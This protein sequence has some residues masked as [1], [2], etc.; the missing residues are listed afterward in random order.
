MMIRGF[1]CWQQTR[2]PGRKG[3]MHYAHT[4]FNLYEGVVGH[5][6]F[7][8][9]VQQLTSMPVLKREGTQHPNSQPGGF[10]DLQWGHISSLPGP[11]SRSAPNEWRH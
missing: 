10:P 1:H 9:V 3:R 4:L 8:I 6:F 5:W 11:V 7:G 2:W